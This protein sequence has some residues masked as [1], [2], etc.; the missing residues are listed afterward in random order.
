MTVDERIQDIFETLFD[1]TVSETDKSRLTWRIRQH[2][3]FA[4]EAEREAGA[5]IAQDHI[6]GL[7]EHDPRD[8]GAS[9]K[10]VT[11]ASIRDKIRAR[12]KA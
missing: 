5:R 7:S 12:G 6:A 3:L 9:Y 8:D 1:S 10:N 11:A 2:M 4:I